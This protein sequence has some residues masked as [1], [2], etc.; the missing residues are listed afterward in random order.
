[1]ERILAVILIMLTA[2]CSSLTIQPDPVYRETQVRHSRPALDG[3]RFD[4]QEVEPRLSEA[5]QAADRKAE[6]KVGNVPRDQNFIQNFWQ[7]KKRI[8]K[9]DYG[10]NWM[11][12]GELN[13]TIRYGSYGQPEITMLEK[14]SIL[15][16]VKDHL[17]SHESVVAVWREFE[18]DV[19][20][21]TKSN[22]DDRSRYYVLSGHDSTWSV[23]RNGELIR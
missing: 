19:W 20:V 23:V 13:P 3:E 17:D 1:M 2:A 16:A 12:P 6:R 8:L 21:S 22:Q 18:G 10:V 14:Q 9:N 15:A 7:A 11:S 4:P 5:F